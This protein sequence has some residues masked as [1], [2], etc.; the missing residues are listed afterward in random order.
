MDLEQKSIERIKLAALMSEQYYD[1]PLVCTYSGGKDSDVMLELF[2]RSG[3]NFEVIS[4]HTTVDAP[5]TVY[6]IREKFKELEDQGIK[7]IVHYPTYKGKRT[8]MWE[9]IVKKGPPTRIHRWCCA[10][11]K[12]KSAPGRMITT[13]VRWEESTRRADRG[14]Y[15]SIEKTVK[16]RKSA[17]YEDIIL[18]NDNDAKRKIIDRCEVKGAVVANPIIDWK[19]K[20]IWEFIRS[21]KIKYN[22]LYDMGYS[23]VGCIGCPMAGYA[24]RSKQ[25]SDFPAYKD[26][27]IKAFDRFL[28]R[29]EAEGNQFTLFKTAQ[30]MFDWWM[31]D[32]KMQGQ[33][34]LFEEE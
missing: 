5:Q 17:T 22:P 13:G 7:A 18:A 23:R 10:V 15:E 28:K 33:V 16:E 1:A 6:H 4:S 9:M 19:N 20:D 29:K 24:Q 11:F 3:V 25:F 27:Y 34:S 26:N 14:E 21:E 12:E 32:P 30:E 2:K 31:E 8:S